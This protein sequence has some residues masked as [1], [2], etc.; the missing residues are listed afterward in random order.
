MKICCS[1]STDFSEI[2]SFLYSSIQP[3]VKNKW[4]FT[5]E[6]SK[7][8]AGVL[9]F[10]S[11][12]ASLHLSHRKWAPALYW[13][14]SR[15]Q[16]SKLFIEKKRHM[17]YIC[18]YWEYDMATYSLLS[19]KFLCF[20]MIHS[21]F[22]I[23]Y[24]ACMYAHLYVYICARVYMCIWLQRPKAD[25]GCLHYSL[26]TLFFEVE[27]FTGTHQLSYIDGPESARDLPVSVHWKH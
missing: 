22:F 11:A 21:L 24:M 9:A 17:Y 8:C 18:T 10:R 23:M 1:F 4:Q 27:S 20:E 15:G 14:L 12:L 16:L 3:R 13:V 19:Y 26:S 2:F 7:F 25:I 6:C 5:G